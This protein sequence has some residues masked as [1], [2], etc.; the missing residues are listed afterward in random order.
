LNR[1]LKFTGIDAILGGHTHDGVPTPVV[2]KNAKGQTLVT[3]AGCSGKFLAVLDLEVKG[4]KVTGFHYKL[5]PI[6]SN[7]LPP[8]PAMTA[9]IDKHSRPYLAKLEEKLAV[10]EGLLYRRGN[11]NG[12][13]DQL[14]LDALMEVKDADIGFSPGFRWGSTILP[15]QPITMEQLMDQT[16]ITYPSTTLTEMTGETIKNVLED[17]CDNMFNPDPYFQQGWRHGSR[18]RYDLHLRAKGENRQAY[19]GNASPRQTYRNS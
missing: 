17:V 12:S 19:R 11:F 2:V 3:N 9:L 6:F 1:P 16:A 8:D 14:I 10:T 7:L 13:W 18:R 4:G 5:L 15:N